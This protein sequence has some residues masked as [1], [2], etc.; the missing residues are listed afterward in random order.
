MAK[1]AVFL[2]GLICFLLLS[3]V[4]SLSD[5]PENDVEISDSFT[6]LP[7]SNPRAQTLITLFLPRE[8]LEPETELAETSTG[9]KLPD[10]DPETVTTEGIKRTQIE[11]DSV[12]L[13]AATFRPINR[14]FVRRPFHLFRDR[15]PCRNHRRNYYQFKFPYG[16]DMIL[17]GGE[18]TVFGPL[19]RVDRR[20]PARWTRFQDVGARF[21]GSR[22]DVEWR[23]DML[24]PHHHHHHRHDVVERDYEE[25]EK[26]IGDGFMKGI[27]KFLEHHF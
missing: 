7:E 23:E 13:T 24:R 16:D 19:R 11:T 14:H 21:P 15:R 6:G 5:Q 2:P 1:L 17:T 18:D 26:K 20:I 22:Y 4:H 3:T 27:R 8:N 12:P 9:T 25:R 10:G